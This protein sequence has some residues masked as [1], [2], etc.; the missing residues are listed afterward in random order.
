MTTGFITLE[1]GEGVGKSTA[2]A[3]IKQYFLDKKRECVFTREP[4]GTKIGE[5]IRA[6]LLHHEEENILPETE[7]FLLFAA[8]AQHIAQVIR[9]ALSAGKIVVSDRFTDSSFAYQGGGRGVSIEKLS[10]LEKWVQGELQPQL[11]LLMDA[12]IEVGLQRMQERNHKDRIEQETKDF[13]QRVRQSY[14]DR[15][16]QFPN[17]FL[18]IKADE[19]IENVNQQIKMALDKIA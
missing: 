13:F 7:M 19:S 9:P 14:L 8:R 2:L 17:R 10:L 15:A 11:T 16:K 1:G 5:A 12:P 3:F 6:I 18:I 4:G